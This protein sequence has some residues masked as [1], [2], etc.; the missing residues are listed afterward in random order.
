MGTIQQRISNKKLNKLM[1]N[2]VGGPKDYDALV[3]KTN[4]KESVHVASNISF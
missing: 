3:G 2:F 1:V 4:G